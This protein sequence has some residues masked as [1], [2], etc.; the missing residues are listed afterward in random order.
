MDAGRYISPQLYRVE[1]ASGP[2]KSNDGFVIAFGRDYWYQ[3]SL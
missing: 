1:S 3:R 2:R